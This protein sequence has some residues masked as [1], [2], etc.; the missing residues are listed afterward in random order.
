MI[1]ARALASLLTT[2]VLAVATPLAAWAHPIHT[3]LTTLTTDRDGLAISVRAFADDLSASVAVFA[4]KQP[5]ADWS[6]PDADAARYLTAS[7]RI[8]DARGVPLTV[9]YCGARRERD[10]VFLCARVDG[11]SD[12]RVLQAE[13]RIL[14]DRHTDQ[15]NIVQIDAAGA[16]KTLL[17][18]KGTR[19]LPLRS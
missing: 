5:P 12:V 10:V 14:T 11:A 18:T 1:A 3:T 2:T 16:R 4:G 9:R 19:A 15:V 17:F 7:V 6:V 8:L 13:N